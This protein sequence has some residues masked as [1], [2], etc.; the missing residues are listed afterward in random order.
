MSRI[1][2]AIIFILLLLTPVLFYQFFVRKNTGKSAVKSV[3]AIEPSRSQEELPVVALVFDDLGENLKALKEI[4]S[5]RI[6]LTIAV[7]PGLKFSRNCAQIGKLSGFSVLVHLPLEPKQK[8]R[9]RVKLIGP[10][11]PLQ[12]RKALL[13]YYLDEIKP[14]IGVNNHMGSLASENVEFMRE[15]LKEVKKRGLFFLDS[16]TSLNSVSCAVAKEEGVVCLEN[17]GFLDSVYEEKVIIR[18][19]ETLL[20][21]VKSQRRLII[22]AHPKEKTLEVLHREIPRLKDKIHFVTLKEYLGK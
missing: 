22:I 2:R 1:V 9:S 7:I 19:I 15:V 14:A 21:E 16:R 17:S 8:I 3:S 11:T 20:E 12:E 5:L 10:S 18:R 4:H 13:K 6:P